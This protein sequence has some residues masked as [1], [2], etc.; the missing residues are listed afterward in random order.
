[1]IV[2]FFV[3]KTDFIESLLCRLLLVYC[4]TGEN[5]ILDIMEVRDKNGYVISMLKSEGEQ[6]LPME[7]EMRDADFSGRVL[8]GI[9]FS[10]TILT[11]ADFSDAILDSC[12]FNYSNLSRTNFSG[13]KIH[14][15]FFL[16][17]NLIGVN[18]Q[19]AELDNCSVAESDCRNSRWDNASLRSLGMT[20]S[21]LNNAVFVDTLFSHS[22]FRG[23]NLTGALFGNTSFNGCDGIHE[24][25]GLHNIRHLGPSKLDLATMRNCV[26][27]VPL[28]FAR[29]VGILPKELEQ[30]RKIYPSPIPVKTC[31][32]FHSTTDTD[33]LTTL[34]NQLNQSGFLCWHYPYNTGFPTE[35]ELQQFFSEMT[36]DADF[37]IVLISGETIL[38]PHLPPM[39]ITAIQDELQMGRQKLIPI[40]LDDVLLGKEALATSAELAKN[41]LWEMDWVRYARLFPVVDFRRRRNPK[42]LEREIAKLVELLKNPP[43]RSV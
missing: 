4:D 41:G 28:E 30:L 16:K 36:I 24:S 39:I 19:L 9:D 34:S 23:A 15:T 40:A 38:M 17:S 1:M 37:L 3:E 14:D 6:C 12:S 20:D 2:S 5:L 35:G 33:V 22:N 13:A 8:R 21:K 11:G 7:K 32:I 42:A 31:Y 26:A 10:R 29:G 27:G 18:F 43:A 25:R